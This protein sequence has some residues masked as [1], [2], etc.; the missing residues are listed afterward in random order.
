MPPKESQ[1]LMNKSTVIIDGP[2]SLA[3]RHGRS[4]DGVARPAA[5]RP[6]ASEVE[7]MRGDVVEVEPFTAGSVTR[8][9][10]VALI[11]L[12]VLYLRIGGGMG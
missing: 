9:V 2:G 6:E 4:D 3:D 10:A 11:G 5:G 8:L 12:I 7:R 1:R